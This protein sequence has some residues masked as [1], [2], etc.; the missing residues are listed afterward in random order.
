MTATIVINFVFI[1]GIRNVDKEKNDF[2]FLPTDYNATKN[3]YSN[4][5]TTSTSSSM[6]LQENFLQDRKS[7]M[8]KFRVTTVYDAK[9]FT[10]YYFRTNNP[11]EGGTCTMDRDTGKAALDQ[12]DL[13]C[14]NWIDPDEPLAYQVNIPSKNESNGYIVFAVFNTSATNLRLP[15]GDETDLYNL[16]LDVYIIDFLGATAKVNLTVIVSM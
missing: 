3:F 16:H 5:L 9:E 7:Y 15:V 10:Y 8:I 11:P 4:L 12:F 6:L 1:V 14:I 2:F 13:A